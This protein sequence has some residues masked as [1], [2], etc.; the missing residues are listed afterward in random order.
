V[1]VIIALS[2]LVASPAFAD[3]GDHDFPQHP[4]FLTCYASDSS[5]KRFAGHDFD[6]D[7]MCTETSAYWKALDSCRQESK[8]PNSCK[9]VPNSCTH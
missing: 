3:R 4:C 9:R 2:L 5:G 7:N 1:K 6:P 8:R